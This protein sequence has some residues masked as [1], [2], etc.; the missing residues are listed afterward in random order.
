MSSLKISLIQPDLAW[1]NKI[2]NLQQLERTID[3]IESTGQIIL[4]PEMFTTGF[5]MNTVALAETMDGT[6]I[7]WMKRWAQKKKSIIA[8]SIIIKDNDVEE[9]CY[10]NRL[11]WMMP[12]GE[13]GYYDKKH[14]FAYAGEDQH[15]TPGA[16]RIIFSVSGWKILPQ[17]CY[18]LRFPVWSRQQV[19]KKDNKT[20]PEFD[21]L[22][23]VA[24]W[25]EKRK[26]AWRSLLVARAIE[27]QCY[28]IGVNRI[29][30]DGNGIEYSGNSMV[31]DPLGEILFEKEYEPTTHQFE[32]SRSHLEACRNRFP[33]L[34]DADNFELLKE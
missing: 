21:V 24:N 14:L 13:Y 18:D 23:Y 7:Q 10:Y 22:L 31:I 1:E 5:S 12:N 16:K 33:F 4:L 20:L 27:N 34:N 3:A 15:Y 11:I 26:H 28:V 32:I 8:G 9:I 2:I 25:P 17:I 6:T 30:R 29:G 19:V